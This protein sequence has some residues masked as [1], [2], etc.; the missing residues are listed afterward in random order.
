MGTSV[1]SEAM[2]GYVQDGFNNLSATVT[3]VVGISVIACVGVIALTAGVNYALKKI[4]G[5]ISKAS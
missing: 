3:Q 5:V 1:L 4:K 2:L